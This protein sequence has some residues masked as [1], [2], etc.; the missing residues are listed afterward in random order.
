[1]T[2]A[3]YRPRTIPITEIEQSAFCR[4]TSNLKS[5]TLAEELKAGVRWQTIP[6]EYRT[7][8]SNEVVDR[9]REARAKLGDRIMILGHHYQRDEVIQ[10]ADFRGDSYNLSKYAAETKNLEAVIFCGVH[11]MAETADILTDSDV[12]VIL[13]NLMAGCSMADMAKIDDVK[14]CW[15]ELTEIYGNEKII[16]ITYMNSTAAIKSLCG[17]NEGIVCTSSNATKVFEWAFER[18]QRVLFLPDQHLGRNTGL[19]LGVPADEM[20]VWSPFKGSGGNSLEKLQK[21]KVVLWEG[22][23]SVHTRFTVDQIQIAREKHP[24]VNIIVHPECTQDVLASADMNGSTELIIKTIT[25]AEPGSVWAVGTEISLVNRLAKE[26]PDKTVFC[27]D[28]VVCPCSTMYR[29][30]PTY[31]LWVL[32]ALNDGV[33]V[34]QITV[35]KETQQNGLIALE[36]MLSVS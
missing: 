14:E 31:L 13:P 19:K 15:D 12:S 10:F 29:I 30:H 6:A 23:C 22:H 7:L 3:K 18:G 25:E 21:A 35:D 17:E 16:P 4:S 27:L 36:R 34:N 33:I 1:M 2:S 8:E 28:P 24:S 26:H 5:K 32:E 11:F 9:I 20:V